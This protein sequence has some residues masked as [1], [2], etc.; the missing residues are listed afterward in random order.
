MKKLMWTNLEAL[1][2]TNYFP[3]TF[4]SM[5]CPFWPSM[6]LLAPHH[7]GREEKKEDHGRHAKEN[8][9]DTAWKVCDDN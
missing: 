5:R 7:S 2:P 1:P 8:T 6:P 3:S 4:S 9:K